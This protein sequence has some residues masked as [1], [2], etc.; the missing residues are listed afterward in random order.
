MTLSPQ[1]H[2]FCVRIHLW[3]LKRS[4]EF[5]SGKVTLKDIFTQGNSW[6]LLWKDSAPDIRWSV[7][8]NVRKTMGCKDI[9][10]YHL[11]ICP[12]C[13]S[14][15]KVKHSCKSRFCSSCG[16]IAAEKWAE[17]SLTSMLDVEYAHLFFTLP[18]EFRIWILYNRKILLD[19]LF[20]AVRETLLD[21]TQKRGYKPGIIMV[22]HTFGADI[23]WIP[24]LH[25]IFT[26]GGMNLNMT[27]W[28]RKN[29]LQKNALMPMY[30]YR[31]LKYF[32]EAF[33]KEDF[34]IPKEYA[35]INTKETLTSWLS[36]F[37]NTYWHVHLGDSLKM[38]DPF[39]KYLSKYTKRPVIAESRIIS[40]SKK[41]VIFEYMDKK[42]KAKKTVTMPI[43]IFLK[44]LLRHIPDI[45]YRM[46]RQAGIFANRVS[47]SILAKA[48]E[49]LGQ[50][51]KTLKKI[52][53]REMIIKHYHYDPMKCKKCGTQ[54]LLQDVKFAQ[55][56]QIKQQLILVHGI[57]L[58]KYHGVE[59]AGFS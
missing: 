39:V 27:K 53:W 10:G 33:S 50:K 32:A 5:I 16:K 25:V 54:M 20:R 47:K 51:K 52:T 55:L 9:L 3:G 48:R 6:N 31:F 59:L 4:M 12:K 44:R 29:K 17:K 23:K 11:Y 34:I 24:H 57:I 26:M 14:Q 41:E 30:R 46:I 40:C 7:L 58:K 49:L 38:A 2:T 1:N 13:K 37:H 35:H 43:R 15:K 19:V 21:Y 42:A 18:Q 28:I 36:Q 45:N 22:M 56:S 8:W